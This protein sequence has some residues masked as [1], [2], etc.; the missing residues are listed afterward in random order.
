MMLRPALVALVFAGLLP[1]LPARADGAAER[2]RIGNERR[3][4]ETRF[5]AEEAACLGRFV[6]TPCV[7]DVRARK[8]EA[9]APLRHQE[10]LLDDAERKRRAA[11]RLQG[12]ETRRAQAASR[13]APAV[14]PAPAPASRPAPSP[15]SQ[16]SLPPQSTGGD[17][18][19]AARRAAAAAEQRRQAAAA[20]RARI[21]ER[22]AA[23]E[24]GSKKSAPLPVPRAVP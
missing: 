23:R 2:Q 20:D 16:R 8:R 17:A 10:L 11:Q 21:A 1:G 13:P 15:P 18:E 19:A 12:I 22:E 4:I 6:V 14:V 9:L 3:A 24:P 7:E 5:A